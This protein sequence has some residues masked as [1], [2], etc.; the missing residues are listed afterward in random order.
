MKRSGIS[1]MEVL[2]VVAV[3]SVLM[4]VG[5]MAFRR[6]TAS[7]ELRAAQQTVVQAIN[8]ARSDARRL[9]QNRVVQWTATGIG[10]NDTVANIVPQSL[11]DSGRV[12]ITSGTNTITYIAPN[13]R[14]NGTTF[15]IILQGRE[16]LQATVR[17][18]GVTGKA[19][20]Q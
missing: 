18:V 8:R 13:G 1:L 2:I 15:N 7:T 6:Y 12:S 5:F 9:S 19:F 20:A 4:T 17:V 16:G 3:I 11:S 10:S 14:T